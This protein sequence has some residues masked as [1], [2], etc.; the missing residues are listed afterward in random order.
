[1]S[2]VFEVKLKYILRQYRLP[3]FHFRHP[4]LS[5]PFAPPPTSNPGSALD[6]DV[7]KWKLFPRNWPFCAG[8]SPVTG[9]FP[10]QRAS[11]ADL[12][13]HRCVSALNVKQTV[14]WPVI[15]DNMTFLWRHRNVLQSAKV[16]L[17]FINCKLSHPLFTPTPAYVEAKSNVYDPMAAVLENTGHSETLCDPIYLSEGCPY[18]DLVPN[19]VR[20]VS[21]FE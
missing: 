21:R 3:L 7:I 6:D 10:S 18:K 2:V 12:M 20:P 5:N 8:N 19:L 14:E 1:M 4:K 17:M 13:L 11:S 15:W 16:T 9:E